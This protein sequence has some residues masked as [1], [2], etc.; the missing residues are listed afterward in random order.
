[1]AKVARAVGRGV[2]LIAD[3]AQ[4]PRWDEQNPKTEL[5]VKAWRERR[6]K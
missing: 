2:L 4:E 6:A 1:M 3:S 5:F